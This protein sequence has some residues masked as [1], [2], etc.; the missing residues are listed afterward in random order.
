M[1]LKYGACKVKVGSDLKFLQQY[2]IVKR[3]ISIWFGILI[4]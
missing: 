3:N 2:V 1:G 4:V